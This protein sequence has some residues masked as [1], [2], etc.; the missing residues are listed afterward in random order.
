MGLRTEVPVLETAKLASE[1]L[2]KL[3]SQTSPGKCQSDQCD[4]INIEPLPS[5]TGDTE[6]KVMGKEIEI[7]PHLEA[8][9][10]GCGF[11]FYE[12][13]ANCHATGMRKRVLFCHVPSDVDDEGIA[14]SR[15][16]LLAVIGAALQAQDEYEKRGD[17]N[18]RRAQFG[19]LT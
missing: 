18:D 4:T 5:H 16:A 10:V 14:T 8:G 15:N 19:E 3:Y 2:Q 17:L 13:M 12:S 7:K 11:T 6:S 1:L 9:D